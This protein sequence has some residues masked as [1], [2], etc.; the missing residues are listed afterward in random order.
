M[1]MT[2]MTRDGNTRVPNGAAMASVVA[3]GVGSCAMGAFVLLAEAGL[4]AAPSLYGPAGGV[5]GRTTFAVL[6]WLTAWSVLH[7]RWRRRE[8]DAARTLRTTLALVGFG[9]VA[10]FPPL[11][12][13]L[14]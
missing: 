7:A 13:L 6:A 14:P 5:S 1:D 12:E 3:A 2:S 9:V 4:Y 10:T 8:V 11:W